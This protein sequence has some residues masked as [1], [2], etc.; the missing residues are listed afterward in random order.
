M[1]QLRYFYESAKTESFAKTAEKYMVPASSVSASVK[2]LEQELETSLFDRTS[3]KI[4][5]NDKGY[6]HF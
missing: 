4:K 5:L 6:Y 1:L 2:R 3:N